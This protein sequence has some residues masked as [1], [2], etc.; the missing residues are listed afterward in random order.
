[1][2]SDRFDFFISYA[3]PDRAWAEWIAVQ[4]ESAGWSV[5]LDSWELAAGRNW[6]Q[7][8][9]EAT[10]RSDSVIAVIS[11]ESL[12]PLRHT[13]EEWFGF[14]LR[15]PENRII[16]VLV[17]PT[18]VPALLRSISQIRIYGLSEADARKAL[19]ASLAPSRTRPTVAPPFPGAETGDQPVPDPVAPPTRPRRDKKKVFISYSHK[20]TDWLERLLVFLK[21]L[22]RAGI[23][24]VWSDKDI[25][26]GRDWHK[27]INAALDLAGI[28]IPL[29]SSDFLAS[30]FIADEELPKLLQAAEQEGTTIL[31]LLVRPSRFER[32]PIL[33]TFQ[34][35]NPPSYPLSALRRPQWEKVLVD[36]SYAIEDELEN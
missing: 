10:D 31:S 24:D 32:T 14:L 36:L 15:G 26:P 35:V 3:A 28:A 9:A 23:I 13:T 34:S 29:I 19:L 2:P 1:M 16:P 8:I 11:P 7:A 21:P 6:V 5:W 4:L 12:G 25:K 22:H 20:D 17:A 27:E 30:D 18:D 33:S